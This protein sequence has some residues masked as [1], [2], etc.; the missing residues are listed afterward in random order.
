MRVKNPFGMRNGKIVLIHDLTPEE[1]G[2]KCN[3][4]CPH[5][6]AHFI[7]KLG[8]VRQPHF[9]HDGKPCDFQVTVM[10]AVY[11]L[12]VEA[13]QENPNFTYPSHYGEYYGFPLGRKATFL[14]IR[15]SCKFY[16]QKYG[17]DSECIIQGRTV[18]ID[19]T[20][21]HKNGKDI[22]NALV[23]TK[24]PVHKLALILVPPASLCASPAPTPFQGLPTIAIYMP[25][26]LYMIR[27]EEIKSVL[28]RSTDNKKWI[29][30]SK[31]DTWLKD[32]QNQQNTAYLQRKKQYEQQR[33]Q[34]AAALAEEQKRRQQ[35][36]QEQARL[37]ELQ[38]KQ[39]QQKALQKETLLRE[40]PKVLQEKYTQLPNHP[41]VDSC[42]TVWYHCMLCKQW[43]P[44]TQMAV[45]GGTEEGCRGTCS[46]CGRK[47]IWSLDSSENHAK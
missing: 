4:V 29:C 8:D 3:C 13:L 44:S 27:S 40:F 22:P 31:I 1:R 12:M 47:A 45:Y 33:A 5:C 41:I 28:C 30:S 36:A 10:T 17:E 18:R 20:Q 7:A 25:E 6:H 19:D 42:G 34:Q 37:R 39:K 35:E 38:L 16:T 24:Y 9:A 2:A 26:D 11:Q 23:L 14:D 43:F 21:I 15:N 32:K 46:R